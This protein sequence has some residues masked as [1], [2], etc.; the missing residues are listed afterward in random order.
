MQQFPLTCLSRHIVHGLES[1]KLNVPILLKFCVLC[2]E[3][4]VRSNEN[5]NDGLFQVR[6]QFN[7]MVA[8]E[9]AAFRT[10]PRKVAYQNA[11]VRMRQV[12]H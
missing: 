12:V 3:M 5:G 6:K 11:A 4:N 8:S 2:F 1:T 9:V 10:I 7:R